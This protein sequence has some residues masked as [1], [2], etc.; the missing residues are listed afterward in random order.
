MTIDTDI[1]GYKPTW[2]IDYAKEYFRSAMARALRPSEIATSSINELVNA[3]PALTR[4]ASRRSPATERALA[5]RDAARE[6]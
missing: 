2:R 6:R 4:S 3:P 1:P 5:R